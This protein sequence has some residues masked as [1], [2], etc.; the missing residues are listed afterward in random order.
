MARR[1]WTADFHL[2]MEALLDANLMQGN[3]RPFSSVDEMNAVLLKSC[4]EAAPEDTIVHLGDLASWG[5]DRGMTGLTEKKPIDIVKSI[6]ATFINLHGNHDTTNK[7]FSVARSMRCSLG[8]RYPAVSASHYPSYDIHAKACFEPGDIHLCGHVHGKW[9]HCLDMTNKVLNI[10]V[11]VDVWGYKIVE[12][13][14]LIVYLNR[15]FK[16]NPDDLYRCKTSADGKLLFAKEKN[17]IY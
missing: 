2:G 14:D 13:E 10:N 3:E 7:V 17:I 15:L 16:R 11:G 9:K 4:Y 8:K 12:D 5:V 6:P 1:W